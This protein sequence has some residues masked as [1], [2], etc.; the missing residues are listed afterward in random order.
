[1]STVPH[2]TDK[3]GP[4]SDPV[5]IKTDEIV[6]TYFGC[7]VSVFKNQFTKDSIYPWIFTVEHQG[8]VRQFGGGPNSCLRRAQ[9]LKRA[10]YRAKWLSE[11]V[12]DEHYVSFDKF[13]DE[14]KPE[15]EPKI[16]TGWRDIDSEALY[17]EI[18]E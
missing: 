10:W 13:L 9:A 6:K 3:F 7:T 11:G 18:V 4:K 15:P 5:I 14:T 17:P 8:N 2:W 12:W 16:E 1:M